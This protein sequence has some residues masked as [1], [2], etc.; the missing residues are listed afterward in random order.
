MQAAVL[1][2]L[3]HLRQ[4]QGGVR[5][6]THRLGRAARY[7][8]LPWPIF[9]L[10][11][12]Q[13]VLEPCTFLAVDRGI[14]SWSRYGWVQHAAAATATAEAAPVPASDA[15]APTPSNPATPTAG[16][17]LQQGERGLFMQGYQ[18]KRGRQSVRLR[19]PVQKADAAT[20]H[21]ATVGRLLARL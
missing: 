7:L 15:V 9:L 20:E 21:A 10:S 6:R 16:L 5:Q 4:N 17:H 8:Y 11:T 1:Q 19:S 13:V 18:H 12:D 3:I 2:R 14:I